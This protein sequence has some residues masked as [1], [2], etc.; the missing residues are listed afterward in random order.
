MFG[1]SWDNYYGYGSRE[2]MYK[3]CDKRQKETDRKAEI[4]H[5][6]DRINK[7]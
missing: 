7:K 6:I 2:E 3:A 1:A 4:Q 5:A